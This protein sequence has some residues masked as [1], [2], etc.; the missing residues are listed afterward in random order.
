MVDGLVTWGAGI[1]GGVIALIFLLKIIKNFIDYLG[2]NGTIKEIIKNVCIFLVGLLIIGFGLSYTTLQ[3]SLKG[4]ADNLGNN[5]INETNKA[6]NSG[7]G[8]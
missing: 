1:C 6:V 7:G 5:I 2:G 8:K 3:N 4:T